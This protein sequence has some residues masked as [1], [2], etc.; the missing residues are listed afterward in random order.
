V[1]YERAAAA[2]QLVRILDGAC[3]MPLMRNRVRVDKVDAVALLEIVLTPGRDDQ[4]QEN[5]DDLIAA[6]LR[7]RD[8]LR[9]AYPVPLTDQVRLSLG[10][11]REL[12]DA[13]RAALADAHPQ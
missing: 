8:V 13:L 4:G 12:A 2:E 6:A 9:A 3:P 11:V 5:N 10:L 7:V 1:Q